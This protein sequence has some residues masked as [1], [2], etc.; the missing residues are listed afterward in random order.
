MG[1]G[2]RVRARHVDAAE[3]ARESVV[4]NVRKRARPL[5]GDVLGGRRPCEAVRG[6]GGGRREHARAQDHEERKDSLHIVP[7]IKRYIYTPARALK[8]NDMCAV[9]RKLIQFP[10]KCGVVD[11]FVR[12]RDETQEY[13]Y[14]EIVVRFRSEFF[15]NPEF[16]AS[17]DACGPAWLEFGGGIWFV[18]KAPGA[19]NWCAE[20]NV[21]Q[22]QPC[23][24]SRC[25]P[26]D[27][28]HWENT[29]LWMHFTSGA[30]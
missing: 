15:G 24:Q 2:A 28:E 3:L 25:A 6:F 16:E 30:S 29:R 19:G 13:D 7:I 10:D 1:V 9:G 12:P 26:C 11:Y 8:V 18:I 23:V 21:M 27:N 5:D 22:A 20:C 17:C 14:P 4:R